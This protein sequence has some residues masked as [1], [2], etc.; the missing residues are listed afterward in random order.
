PAV[1]VSENVTAGPLTSLDDAVM[2]TAVPFVAPS[3]TLPPVAPSVS[4]GVVGAT[5]VTA[6][7]KLC[8]LVPPAP[9]EGC[10]VIWCEVALSKL[11]LLPS[12]TVTT[13]LVGS[14]ANRP[15]AVSVSEN[16]TAGPLTSLDDAVMQIGRASCRDRAEVPRL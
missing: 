8:E 15:P 2:P 14:I 13:P 9:S 16:V 4:V 6:I 1:S 11:S 7:V 3:A 10:T 5:L 12:A